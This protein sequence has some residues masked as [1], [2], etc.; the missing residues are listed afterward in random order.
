MAE[1]VLVVAFDGLDL[2]RIDEYGLENVRQDEFGTI[3][4]STGISTI[5]TAELFT[6][7]LTG[8]THEEHGVVGLKKEEKGGEPVFDRVLHAVPQ[9]L[10]DAVNTGRTQQLLNRMRPG[11]TFYTRE[12]IQ[13]ATL[14]DEIPGSRDVNVP[15]YSRNTYLH[16][17]YVGFE[18][19]FGKATVR[20]DLE[21]EHA[22]RRRETFDAMDGDSRFVMSHFFYPDTFQ[23]LYPGEDD[24]LQSMYHRMDGLAGDILDRAGRFDTVIF[25]SDHGRPTR[26]AHNEEA[27]YSCNRELFPDATPRITD[28]HDRILDLVGAD[29]TA[30]LDI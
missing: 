14:F 7:F 2:Q 29:D 4:N 24:A 27:F 8:T 25:M 20:R 26:D 21:A 1:S 18:L 19:G 9:R 23:H 5:K 6:S 3:D 28:F 13:G 11:S 10:K 16:R 12:D 15:V 22:Q 30:G 17:K